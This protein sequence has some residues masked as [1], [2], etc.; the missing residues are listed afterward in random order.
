M[1]IKAKNVNYTYAEGTAYEIHALKDINLEIPD[2]QF[3]G[4]IGHTGSGKSTLVQHLNG[5]VKATGGRIYFD[6]RDIYGE[7]F[8][9]KELR[10]KV[11]LVFQYP[12][13]QLF[14]TD[15]L[16]DVCFGP[17]N[18]GFSKEEAQKKAKEALRMVGLGEE[19][20]ARSP[21]E[22]SGGQ[23][24]RVAIAG[25]LAMNPRVLILDEP[26]AGLDPKGRD[27]ILDQIERLQKERGIT[28]VLV[29]H[30][31]EDVA[32]YVDRI[33]VM[34]HGEVRFDGTPKE[35]FR[36]YKELEEIG[37]AAPQMTYLMQKL[38]EKGADVDTD[39]TTVE[40]A[41]ETIAS[42]LRRQ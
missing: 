31:M 10:S 23:K 24:R 42:W 14:E 2:G 26:T 25:V 19:Y 13:H 34:N 18:L 37:L 4:L 40:E 7:N 5:L 12:E 30:S 3:V 11:G 39:A 41:A 38:K 36:H 15:V 33:I 21:F 22:L 29:S 1:S 6:G 32:R 27:E 16:T 9:M 20:D 8:S 17:K 28:V 35:V